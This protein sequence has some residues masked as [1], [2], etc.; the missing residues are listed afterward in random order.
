MANENTKKGSPSSAA[1]ELQAPPQTSRSLV[2]SDMKVA[3]Q[4]PD[5]ATV[6]SHERKHRLREDTDDAQEKMSTTS[7][8]Q[9]GVRAEPVEAVER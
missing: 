5:S 2:Q 9:Q 6:R 3:Q 7:G 8:A 1:R 4:L